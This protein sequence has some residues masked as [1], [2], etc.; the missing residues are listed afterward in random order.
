MA[1]EGLVEGLAAVED[2]IQDI[3]RKLPCAWTS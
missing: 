2:A 3:E 1:G